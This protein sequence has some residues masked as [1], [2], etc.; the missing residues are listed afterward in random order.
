MITPSLP[1]PLVE[2]PPLPGPLPC[3]R[4][5]VKRD[6]LVH[7]LVS[8]NKWRKLK[9]NLQAAGESGCT[10]LVTTGGAYSNH[11]AAVA[12]AGVAQGFRTVG[13]VRGECPPNLNPTLRFL[14]SSGME[15]HFVSRSDF[16]T[17]HQPGWFS[18]LGI[19]T[20]HAFLLPEGGTNHL[21]FPGLRELVDELT[22][23]LPADLPYCIC[24]A[25]GTGGTLAGLAAALPA[26]AR[27]L[28]VAVLKGDFLPAEVATF[29]SGNGFPRL[30][31]W[32]VLPDYHFGGYARFSATLLDFIRRFH[33][34][35][36]ILLDP[37]YTGKMAFAAMDLLAKGF[38]QP[39]TA[40]VL[41]HTGGLQGVEGFRERFPD[42]PLP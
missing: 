27:A 29:L 14:Q 21:V 24:T 30:D 5:F 32:S 17:R 1:S 10:S 7:P 31:N 2:L 15:L 4:I 40:V 8:G 13:V 38:F 6:D 11:L 3:P 28:G 23:Q 33:R 26:R 41:L 19:D 34:A 16:R 37:V 12:A 39:D 25:C 20:A 18:R 22:D 9:F 42:L 35:Y 36:G